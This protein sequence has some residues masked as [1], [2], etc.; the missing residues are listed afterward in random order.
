MPIDWNRTLREGAIAGGWASVLSTV[1][2]LC[3]GRRQARATVTPVNAVS[4]WF[5]GDSALREHRTRLSHTL[6]GYLIHHGAS[7]FWAA[8]SA[9]AR[10][11]RGPAPRETWGQVCRRA[12][13]TSAAACYVDFRLTPRRFTPGFEHHLSR[14][15]LAAVY[16]AFGAGLAIGTAMVLRNG[17][18][19]APRPT[20]PLTA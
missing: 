1:A 18:A 8:A 17:H 9:A 15:A 10:D 12:A 4:H 7:V 3:A 13:V 19:A 11:A 20:P 14:P 16:A 5:W 6:P 2:L